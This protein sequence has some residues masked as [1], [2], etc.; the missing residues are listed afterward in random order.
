MESPKK[1]LQVEIAEVSRLIYSGPCARVVAPA[2]LGEVC[3]LPRHAPLLTKLLPGVIQIQT[4]DEERQ[5]FYLSG[6]FMEVKDSTVYVLADAMLRSDEIDREAA[7]AAQQEAESVLRH[8]HLFT[9]R[10]R[11]KVVLAKALAQLRVLEHAEVHR[12]KKQR[13]V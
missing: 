4:E 2:A 6:G 12:L 11:A 13:G 8:S 9:E 7:L 5:S 3:I 1:T 10:D